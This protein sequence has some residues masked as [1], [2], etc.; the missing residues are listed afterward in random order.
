MGALARASTRRPDANREPS[1]NRL[2]VVAM[3]GVADVVSEA[4]F[5]GRAVCCDADL[6][7]GR[8]H[9]HTTTPMPW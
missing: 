7:A 6:A 3:A 2:D 9:R 1:S 4:A 8:I 5:F